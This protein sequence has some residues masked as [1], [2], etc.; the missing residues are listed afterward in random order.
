MAVPD[1]RPD[2]TR[3]TLAVLF[4]AGLL[5]ATFAIVRPFVPAMIWAVTL[6]IATWPVMLRVQAV[7][8]GSRG[9]AVAVMTIGLLLLLIV[10]LWLAASV[11]IG[12]IDELGRIIKVALS[13]EIPPVP[14]WVASIPLAGDWIADTWRTLESAGVHDLA[15]R[16]TPYAGTITRWIVGSLGSLGEMFVQLLLT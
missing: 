13:L 12:N 4:V 5:V 9:A 6:V 8:A 2:L 7:A 11:V 14:D 10:P 15:P 16:L 3:T 1:P